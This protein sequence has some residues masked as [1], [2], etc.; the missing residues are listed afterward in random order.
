MG[1]W[2]QGDTSAVVDSENQSQVNGQDLISGSASGEYELIPFVQFDELQGEQAYATQEIIPFGSPRYANTAYPEPVTDPTSSTATIGSYFFNWN[3]WTFNPVLSAQQNVQNQAKNIDLILRQS[4]NSFSALV[5]NQASM[6]SELN[7]HLSW[8]NTLWDWETTGRARVNN[9][10][11]WSSGVD[12][13]NAT[14]DTSI[15]SNTS[16]IS[17]LWTANQDRYNDISN[18]WG[19]NATQDTTITS[20]FTQATKWNTER[21]NDIKNIWGVNATQDTTITSN[22]TQAT[23]WNT[24]RYNDIKNIWG[25]NETQDTTISNLRKDATQWNSERATQIETIWGV[26]ATQDTT[27]TSNFT[28]ATKWNTERYNDIK[29]IWGVNETQDT[30]ISN[31]RKDATQWNSERATQIETI[32]GVNETQDTTISNLR[33]DATQWNTDRYNEIRGVNSDSESR[34]TALSNRLDEIESFD[35]G[36]IIDLTILVTAINAVGSKVQKLVDTFDVTTIKSGTFTFFLQA[37]IKTQ[38]DA[39][40]QALAMVDE[41]INDNFVNYFSDSKNGQFWT[42]YKE[43]SDFQMA[44]FFGVFFESLQE[45]WESNWLTVLDVWNTTNS[46]LATIAGWLDQIQLGVAD[47]KEILAIITNWLKL[48]YEKPIASVNVPSFDFDRLERILKKLEFGEVVNEAGTNIWDFLTGLV[49]TLG[50]LIETQLKEFTKVLS[51]ILD[52]L[53]GLIDKMIGLIVPQNLDFMRQGFD[54]VNLKFKAKFGN[55]LNISASI[56]QMFQPIE[57]DFIS[58]LSFDFMGVPFVPDIAILATFVPKFRNVVALLMWFNVG[59]W[60]FRRFTGT[61]DV[62]N[63][64]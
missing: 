2:A 56:T 12:K 8:I 64:N 52:F 50:D 20:N 49:D 25:V 33:K 61:G 46:F 54:D 37:N 31:L 57:K 22:F 39:I 42:A 55:F 19:V 29:N 3:V 24:E 4:K 1:V 27:I 62:V 5:S 23:K 21:Y 28:Q 60:A 32:W 7:S 11:T 40:T 45:E 47:S 10:W 13:K 35:F 59:W 48:I 58:E 16:S 53:D 26:N 9:L 18:I 43:F 14:Q 51:E 44:V 63:D 17:Q 38:T 34:D 30:T 36:S 6:A 41:S 15:S